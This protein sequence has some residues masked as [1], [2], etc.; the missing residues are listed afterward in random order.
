VKTF[1]GTSAI[2]LKF[3]IWTAFIA[4]LLIKDL[5]CRASFVWSVSN[6]T[7]LLRRQPLAAVERFLPA[8]AGTRLPAGAIA[9]DASLRL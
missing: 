6:L 4:T 8:N 9:A 5:Q 1:A 2:A 3:Q 7:A